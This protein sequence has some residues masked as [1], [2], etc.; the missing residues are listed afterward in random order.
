[1][2]KSVFHLYRYTE[3][4][5]S[6]NE[7]YLGALSAVVPLHDCIKELEQLAQ[8]VQDGQNRHTGFNPLSPEVTKVFEAVPG[9]AHSINGF[10]NKDLRNLLFGDN[11][12][13]PEELKKASSKITRIIRKLRAH[14]LI[15]KISRSTRYKVTEKGYRILGASLE[16]KKKYLPTNMKNAA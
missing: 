7:R 16:M 12:G 6:A 1:M 13:S 15:S 3:V 8:P 9:G 5:K 10:R 4:S 14:C 2:G 11:T